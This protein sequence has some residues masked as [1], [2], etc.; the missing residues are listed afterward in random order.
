MPATTTTDRTRA[1]SVVPAVAQQRSR[2]PTTGLSSA[3]WSAPSADASYLPS[4]ISLPEK[5]GA[6]EYTRPGQ[7]SARLGL[8]YDPV[9]VLGQLDRPMEFARAVLSLSGEVSPRRL[10]DRRALL[11][12]LD[13]MNQHLDRSASHL[14][15]AAAKAFSLLTAPK[16][17]AAFDL[18]QEPQSVRDRYGRRSTACRC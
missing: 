4:L 14:L 1:R 15:A 7:F 5:P 3:R 12:L 2:C 8:E 13:D 9:Y 11:G 17:K 16:T 6:P 10:G 18:A